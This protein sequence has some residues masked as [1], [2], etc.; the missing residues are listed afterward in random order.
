MLASFLEPDAS[1]VGNDSP[2]VQL[3]QIMPLFKKRAEDL[4]V[5]GHELKKAWDVEL[6]DG[7][8]TVMYESISTTVFKHDP[9]KKEL[10][11]PEFCILELVQ[12]SREKDLRAGELRS[13]FDPATTARRVQEIGAPKEEESAM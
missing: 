2:P 6:E 4:S 5:F 10:K 3:A 7:K 8:R 9:E 11:V 1:F 13:W 12:S